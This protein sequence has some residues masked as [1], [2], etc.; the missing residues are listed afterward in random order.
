MGQF[1]VIRAFTAKFIG[2]ILACMSTAKD[3]L[4][5]QDNLECEARNRDHDPV[6]RSLKCGWSKSRL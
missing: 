6:I 2:E 4:I 1:G 3:S 5:T